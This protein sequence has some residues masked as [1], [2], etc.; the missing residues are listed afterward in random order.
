MEKMV[1]SV[2]LE[3][4]GQWEILDRQ[5]L[6][7]R[8]ALLGRKDRLVNQANQENL[9]VQEIQDYLE[10]WVLQG[11]KEKKDHKD[12]LVFLEKRVHPVLVVYQ[13]FLAS[14]G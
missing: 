8:L 7:A 9:E 3:N 12:H 5:V 14:E 10:N 4:E 2:L 11:S 1:F 13:D 6:Q